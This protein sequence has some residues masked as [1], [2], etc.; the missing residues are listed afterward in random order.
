MATGDQTTFK[1]HNYVVNTSK[2]IKLKLEE[3]G[4]QITEI[5]ILDAM[6]KR[7]EDEFN[8]VKWE[9]TKSANSFVE[10]IIEDLHELIDDGKVKVDYRK[11][12]ETKV[13]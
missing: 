5:A 3:E 1:C 8:A 7:F 9:S 11:L 10:K 13:T 6:S 2:K 4:Y 12:P